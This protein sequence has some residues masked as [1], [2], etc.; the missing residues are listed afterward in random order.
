[1]F[2]CELN[3]HGTIF[4]ATTVARK[5]ETY[6]ISWQSIYCNNVVRIWNLFSCTTRCGNKRCVKIV[7]RR[8][9]TRIDFLCDNVAL[10]IVAKNCPFNQGNTHARTVINC[11]RRVNGASNT[12]VWWTSVSKVCWFLIKLSPSC[13]CY[14]W[15]DKRWCA[16]YIDTNRA[17]SKRNLN[18]G[19]DLRLA[20]VPWGGTLSKLGRDNGG[21]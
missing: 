15:R 2:F 21:K 8:H 3:E 4:N 17:L 19:S 12:P 6:S 11:N 1:M 18:L 5:L 10:K 20:R 14:Q 16:V 9:V 7:C 13:G